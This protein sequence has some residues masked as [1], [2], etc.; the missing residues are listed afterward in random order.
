[1][2][3]FLGIGAHKS[4]T[5]WLHDNLATHPDIWLPEFKELHYFD[6]IEFGAMK[7]HELRR[8]KWLMNKVDRVTHERN[9]PP[10]LN[11]LKS[12]SWGSKFALTSQ[13]KR[14]NDWYLS[15]FEEHEQPICGEITPAYALLSIENF[16]RI[17]EL[18]PNVKLIFFLRNPI[19]RTWSSYRYDVLT[20]KVGGINQKVSEKYDF[21][22]FKKYTKRK[23]VRDRSD[24]ISTIEKL[25]RVFDR[26]QTLYLFF[27]DLE[28]DPLE[29]LRQVCKFLGVEYQ[30]NYFPNVKEK[31]L[32]S[33]E[34]K[35]PSEAYD[36][37]RETCKNDMSKLN[38]RLPLPS[39]WLTHI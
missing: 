31:S 10:S 36:Y 28:N 37:L 26:E 2:L 5:T 6:Q 38:E 29:L 4:G 23:A 27:D 11:D 30:Q 14:D 20:K 18:N 25:E 12:L 1:M 8:A 32:V 3:N 33:K 22:E 19:Y 39:E 13:E 34:V 16:E 9:Y 24:Y 17:K 21:K 35:I 15:L 7:G